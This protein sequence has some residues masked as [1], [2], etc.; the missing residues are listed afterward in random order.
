MTASSGS[1]VAARARAWGLVALTV[2][3]AAQLVWFAVMLRQDDPPGLLRPALFTV[4]MALLALSRGRWRWAVVFARLVIGGAFVDALWSRFNDFNGFIAYTSLVNSF[5]PP[6]WAPALAVIATVFESA[7]AGG[8]LLGIA[9][10]WAAGGSA[11]LLCVFATAMVAS[12][13]DQ[14]EWAVYVLAAGA[15]V[16]VASGERFLTLDG[17][18]AARG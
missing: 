10:R 7:F 12:G 2:A 4:V 5:L 18:M 16:V 6:S 1:D 17:L 15:W 14:F 3:I 13:L 11:V 8:I 9:T